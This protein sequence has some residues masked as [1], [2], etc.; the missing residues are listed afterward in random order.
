MV[1][2]VVAMGVW[3]SASMRHGLA[4]VV[5]GWREVGPSGAAEWRLPSTA[6][7]VQARRRAGARLLRELFQAVAGPVAR[8]ATAGSFLGDRRLMAVDGTTIDVADTSENERA[9][10]RPT[11]PRGTQRGAFPQIRVVALIETGTH[12]ICDAVLRPVRCGEVPAA[13]RLLR[14]V[15]PGMLLLWDRGFH[16]SAMIRATLARQADVLG[17]TKSNVVLRPVEVLADGSFLARVYPTPT[18][19]HRDADGIVV[20]VV[21]YALDTPA[22]PGRE[23]YR[24][25]TSLLDERTFPAERLAATS[26]ERW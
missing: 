24:L 1:P 13:L 25:L 6:A 16:S 4:E 9:V 20:R 21:A 8:P 23:T 15:G 10:G 18:A 12:A 14:S 5:A 22:G 7:I 19:R 17:R 26:H 11:T 3:A 2:L